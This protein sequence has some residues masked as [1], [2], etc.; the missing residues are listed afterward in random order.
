MTVSVNETASI[1]TSISAGLSIIS[2][3]V[4]IWTCKLPGV[5]NSSRTLLVWLTIAD[6]ATAFGNLLG[7]VRFFCFNKSGT[8]I[9]TSDGLCVGQS[10]ITTMS[11]LSSF[12]WTSLI[13]IHL[14]CALLKDIDITA[15]RK[16]VPLMHAFSWGFPGKLKVLHYRGIPYIYTLTVCAFSLLNLVVGI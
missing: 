6:I 5:T 3:V 11:S 10:F 4:I 12:C 14:H 13:A 2:G 9:F 7:A 15:R 8:Y 16:A 1:I